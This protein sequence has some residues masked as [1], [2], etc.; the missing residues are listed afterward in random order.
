MQADQ[1]T[2]RPNKKGTTRVSN[3]IFPAE[4]M[5]LPT[6]E[7]PGGVTIYLS[8]AESHV[9]YYLTAAQDLDYPAHAHAA[10]FAVVLDGRIDVTTNS[11]TQSYSRGDRYYLPT[12]TEHCVK[13]HAG[14]AEMAYLDDPK[15]FG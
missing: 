4:I 3:N 1:R 5:N 11:G 13:L 9:V 8:K 14:F 2:L 12:G 15:Y 10:Q 7:V 6:I